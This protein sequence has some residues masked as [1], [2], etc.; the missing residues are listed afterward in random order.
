MPEVRE[1]GKRAL[2]GMKMSKNREVRWLFSFRPFYNIQCFVPLP[3]I[4]TAVLNW[5][6]LYSFYSL[7]W[8]S[9][10]RRNRS[11]GVTVLS[12]GT[13]IQILALYCT[14]LPTFVPKEL[15]L[16][17]Y[18]QSPRF[19]CWLRGPSKVSSQPTHVLAP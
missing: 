13:R 19:T 2:L 3:S 14:L 1:A 7:R 6:C 8:G 10:Q 4:F 5:S 18:C 9:P 11:R 15:A 17:T 12:T 16:R